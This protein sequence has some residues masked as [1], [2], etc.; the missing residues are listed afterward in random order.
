MTISSSWLT[1]PSLKVLGCLKR[2]PVLHFIQDLPQNLMWH[3]RAIAGVYSF[4]NSGN[5]GDY[6]LNYSVAFH[7][8]KF[9]IY[10]DYCYMLTVGGGGVK[11]CKDY[12]CNQ[13]GQ[14]EARDNIIG[15]ILE[16]PFIY[17]VSHYLWLNDIFHDSCPLN[18]Y[19][20]PDTW[21]GSY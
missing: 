14:S 3:V 12:K 5:H 19:S 20:I 1:F 17:I 9:A 18:H 16:K 13:N 11:T 4:V 8:T 7:K 10:I 2:S 15:S 6:P 21:G